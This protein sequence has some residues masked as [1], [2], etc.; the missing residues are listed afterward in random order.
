MIGMDTRSVKQWFLDSDAVLRRL[1]RDDRKRL[2]NTGALVRK[3]ARNSMKKAR[4]MTLGEMTHEQRQRYRMLQAIAKRKGKDPPLKPRMAS[5]PGEPPRVRS[6]ELKSQLF[7]AYDPSAMSVVVG[8]ALL[9]GAIPPNSTQT[10]PELLEFGGIVTARGKRWG[11]V[12]PRP[13]MGP[14][15][16]AAIPYFVNQWKDSIR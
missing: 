6:G 3:I 16:D 13:Y 12:A 11:Y 4:Q 9:P 1:R 5:K 10:A 7:F 2:G 15:F 8:P 14:A